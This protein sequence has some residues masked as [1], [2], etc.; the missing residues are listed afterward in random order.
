MKSK[1]I[2]Q[3][4]MVFVAF[5]VTIGAFSPTSKAE[6]ANDPIH[7]DA[8]AAIIVEA[9]S[10]KILYSKNAD[11]RLP[12]ASMA[13]MMTEYLLLEAIKEGK[14]KWDQKYTPDDYVYE[15][16]QD[17][18]LSNVP[19]RKDGSYTVKELYEATAI[20][21]ANAAAI[22]LSEIIAGSESKFVESMN[23]KAKEL[24]MKNYKFVNATGLENK[25]LHGK[26]PSGT[27][28]NDENKVSARD[29]ALLADRLVKKYPEILDTASISKM[30][31]RKGTDD[32]MDMPN[33]NFMLKGLVQ[34]YK[35]VDGLK[36]GSTDSA[37][38]CFT[39]TA[40]R[41]GMRVISVVLDAKGDL[42]T[43]RFKE[44]KKMLDYAFNH[45]SMKQLYDKNETIKGN[46]TVEV[47][48]GKE[49]EVTIV[50][51]KALNIPV[52]NGEEKHYKA[53][54]ILD[55]KELTAPVK[56]GEKVGRLS[57]SY[58]GEEK[59]YGFLENNVS[60]VNLVAKEE[61]E[62]ANWFVLTMRSIGSFF[63]NLWNSIV[64]I[65]TGWF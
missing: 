6:A 11:K 3:L 2:K 1:K 26:H 22:A 21:S 48:K 38:S 41:N 18:S 20:Y 30:K 65:V 12:I 37:G 29:M 46:K 49:Q 7:V 25:E 45:F 58:K 63:A 44:T 24:G 35:G 28:P 53:K 57:V 8:K 27:N 39:A 36:T 42:H 61:V 32:E 23:K 10:G 9:S 31:F 52:K 47:D 13:K 50:T 15:I 4:V 16:S 5:A 54:A 40:E 51:D 60:D 19:L 56:K 62:E 55:H 17:K 64:D 43:G 34:E 14:V 59:D 33:W